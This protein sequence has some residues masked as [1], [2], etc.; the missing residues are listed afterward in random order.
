[1]IALCLDALPLGHQTLDYCVTCRGIWFDLHE[2]A[3][4]A[5]A[6]ILE[7]FRI[8]RDTQAADTQPIAPQLV[9]PRCRQ[10]LVATRDLVRSGPF[11]YHRC[12]NR[13]GRFTPFA[14]FLTEKGFVRHLAK[15][16]IDAIAVRIGQI[17]CHACG[18]PID[19][20]SNTACPHCRAPIAVLDAKAM[21]KAFDGYGKAAAPRIRELSGDLFVSVPDMPFLPPRRGTSLLELGIGTVAGLFD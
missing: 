6:S 12:P 4:L 11:A 1:M 7:L 14:Q 15:K 10:A 5:P 16:E 17:N 13:H 8:I 3:R 2:S 20:R 21:S 19:L 9:C 18:G